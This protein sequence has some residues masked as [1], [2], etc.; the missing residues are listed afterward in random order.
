M[1][2]R[3]SYKPL[4]RKGLQ[5]SRR[6]P[7]PTDRQAVIGTAVGQSYL[8]YGASLKRFIWRF[9][10]NR[11]DVEDVAQEAFLR[12]YAV[13]RNR[14]ITQPKSFLFRIA[15][16]V[17]LSTLDRK[18]RQI[19]D[20]IE[21]VDHSA[22]ACDDS[23]PEEELRAQQVLGLHCEAIAALRPQCRRAYLLRKVH[24]LSHKEIAEHLGLTVSTVEKHL[25]KALAHCERYVREQVEGRT[26][27]AHSLPDAEEAG[28]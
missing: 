16:H 25:I 11:L 6:S 12:A 9:L 28:R 18:A 8:R 24:G 26:T 22:I 17:A 13:E 10:R 2:P 27:P 15:K 21:D 23:S 3:H 7:D 4:S 1:S 20:Y 5:M 19:T 14:P